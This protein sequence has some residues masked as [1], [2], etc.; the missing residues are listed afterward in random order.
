MRIINASN[1][2]VGDKFSISSTHTPTYEVLEISNNTAK[3]K[4]LENSI[5]DTA[6]KLDSVLVNVF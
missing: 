3:I 5:I 1:L 2:K 6:Q 4:R